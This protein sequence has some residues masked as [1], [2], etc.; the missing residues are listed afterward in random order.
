MPTE[1]MEDNIKPEQ[2]SLEE[3]WNKMD[4]DKTSKLRMW[5][6]EVIIN[7]ED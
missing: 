4:Q 1:I 7:G 2:Y 5:S 6:L 3:L